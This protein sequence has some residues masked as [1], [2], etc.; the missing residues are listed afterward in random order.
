MLLWRLQRSIGE[1]T[2]MVCGCKHL[3]LWL[4]ICVLFLPT[5]SLCCGRGR[6]RLDGDQP[7]HVTWY[8][9]LA[10]DGRQPQPQP[11]AQ[12]QAHPQC[13]L[14]EEEEREA[15]PHEQGQKEIKIQLIADIDDGIRM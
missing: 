8:A 9:D 2:R 3:G 14:E 7:R 13:E 15:D 4:L 11:Q 10:E 6:D 1:T 5:Y 12:K